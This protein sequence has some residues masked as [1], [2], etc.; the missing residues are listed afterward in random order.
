MKRLLEAMD[1]M[2]KAAKKETG[3][4]FPG[5]WKGTDPAGKARSKMVGS[6]EESIIK[7]LAKTAKDKVTEWN[8]EEAF[9]G[10]KEQVDDSAETGVRTGPHAG[11]DA[12]T[13]QR[14]QAWTQA[15][16]NKPDLP[17]PAVTAEPKITKAPTTPTVT[18]TSAAPVVKPTAPTPTATI[19]AVDQIPR[20]KA[21]S[22]LPYNPVVGNELTRN[23]QNTLAAMPGASVTRAPTAARMAAGMIGQTANNVTDNNEIPKTPV[24]PKAA[25]SVKLGFGE[26]GYTP[27]VGNTLEKRGDKWYYPGSNLPVSGAVA[28]HAETKLGQGAQPT[29]PVQAPAAKA[30]PAATPPG[31]NMS[32]KQKTDVDRYAGLH[33]EFR[34]NLERAVKDYGK[35][36]KITSTIRTEPEQQELRAKAS[37][38]APGVHTPAPTV[39]SHGG[40]AV[41]VDPKNSREFYSWLKKADPTGKIYNL[42]HGLDFRNPDPVHL[43]HA[44]YTPPSRMESKIDRLAKQFEQFV[45]NT[46]KK[47]AG[48]YDPEEFDAK[49]K[50]LGQRAKQGPMKTVWDE[51]TRKY[52]VVPANAATQVKEYGNAQDPNAQTTSAPSPAAALKAPAATT[53]PAVDKE[54]AIDTATAKGTVSSLK[55]YIGPKT[56]INQAASAVT[57]ISDNKPLTRPEQEAIAGIT[58]L[59]MKAAETPAAATQLKSALTTAGVMAKVGK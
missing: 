34:S 27:L 19:S 24:T 6:A 49:V 48:R 59:V 46:D 45:E 40:Y 20:D 32:F 56:D 21:P 58:P 55:P 12:A 41:D 38:G 13:R 50:H 2:S 3:P 23:V 36:M 26:P 47:I 18:P 31:Q 51:R 43:Q 15:Q 17:T 37:R 28:K 22:T 10:F 30:A 4:K 33:P 35:P 14:A 1:S 42:K 52:K 8:L 57:K 11:I 29:T 5:Y 7:D 53:Q 9:K 54:Q 39:Q 44:G 25:S 16:Q